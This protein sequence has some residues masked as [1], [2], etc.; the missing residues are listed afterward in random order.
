MLQNISSTYFNRWNACFSICFYTWTHIHV[1]LIWLNINKNG[2]VYKVRFSNHGTLKLSLTKTKTCLY[3]F[4][5]LKPHFYIVK[6]GFTGV[7]I[8][9]FHISV[10]NIDCEYQLEQPRRGSSNE[11]LQ[12]IF[13]AEMWK[14]SEF[15]F[16]NFHFFG[17]KIFN[18]E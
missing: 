13:W 8:I 1:P 12:S 10:L 6:L 5:S 2:D 11:Y 7:Y 3:N 16:E 15:L 14:I 9:F 17:G 4:D 18:F